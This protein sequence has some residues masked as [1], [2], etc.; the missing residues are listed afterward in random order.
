MRFSLRAALASLWAMI[1]ALCLALAVLM[2]LLFEQGAGA[3]QREGRQKVGRA[4]DEA[5]M[6]Y[7]HYR[8]TFQ[9][10][11][12]P[13]DDPAVHDDLENL[14]AVAFSPH[15]GVEGGFWRG[16]SGSIAYAFPTHDGPRRKR[17]LPQ[18]ELGQIAGIVRD[19]LAARAPLDRRYDGNAVSLLLHAQPL[20]GPPPDLA[21]WT[22]S[23][24]PLNIG[25]G[26]QSL[27]FGLGALLLLALGSGLWLMSSL[28]R[29]TRRVGALEEA[30]AS[31]PLEELP[32][33]RAVGERELDRVVSALQRPQRAF[34]NGPGGP[35]AH[36]AR[37]G[38]LRPARRA[39]PHGRRLGPRDRQPARRDASAQR[40][41]P[42]R[43]TGARPEPPCAPS[44]RR[45]SAW[46]NCSPP[47]A[48]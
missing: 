47:C 27:V 41:R 11:P 22:M 6:R 8:R 48:C 37:P 29:W 26:Y 30:I 14:L 5:A 42:R 38:A 17:D 7:D 34:A 46:R 21:A 32:R 1:L 4:A 35:R 19:S 10:G 31:T 15:P 3:Q 44:C 25:R 13:F 39:G 20:P 36:G 24:A 45:S 23:R 2:F 33:L 40:E 12:P 18:A 43:R 16:E 9:N 28:R